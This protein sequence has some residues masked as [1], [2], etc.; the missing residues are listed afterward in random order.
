MATYKSINHD[1]LTIYP[2][3]SQHDDEDAVILAKIASLSIVT[4]VVVLSNNSK[5][6]VSFNDFQD[7][8]SARF[9]VGLFKLNW[10]I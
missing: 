10:T 8:S 9:W 3:T 6:M 1:Y 2:S 7:L 4:G 5:C